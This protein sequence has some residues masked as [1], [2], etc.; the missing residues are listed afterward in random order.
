M[1]DTHRIEHARIGVENLKTAVSFYRD[2]LGLVELEQT[3]DVVYLGCGR[4]DKSAL[5]PGN[6]RTHM[7]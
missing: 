4:D 5:R 2:A 6:D 7:R 3:D 1:A